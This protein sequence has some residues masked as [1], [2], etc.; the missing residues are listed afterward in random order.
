MEP[1]GG[2]GGLS[3]QMQASLLFLQPACSVYSVGQGEIPLRDP[4]P[5]TL[6]LGHGLKELGPGSL[7]CC[8]GPPAGSGLRPQTSGRGKCSA[9]PCPPRLRAR[10]RALS[11]RSHTDQAPRALRPGAAAGPRRV[12]PGGAEAVPS[13]RRTFGRGPLRPVSRPASP[14]PGCLQ[15]CLTAKGPFL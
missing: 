14:G 1:P 5:V 10:P 2:N 15:P 3:S 13:R 9:M 12:L 7:A 6:N 4:P 8:A 11:S